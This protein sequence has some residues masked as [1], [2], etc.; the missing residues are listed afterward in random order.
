M[1]GEFI[2]LEKDQDSFEK[3]AYTYSYTMTVLYTFIANVLLLNLLIAMFKYLV[4]G[5]I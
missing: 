1:L 3:Y 5:L 4:K 2:F